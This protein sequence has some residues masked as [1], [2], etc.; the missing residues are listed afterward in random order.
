MSSQVIGIDIGSRSVRAIELRNPDATKPTITRF[1]EVALTADAVRR[2]EVL[3]VSTVAVAIKQ[4]WKT[5]GFT[6]RNVILGMG[7]SRVL[8]RDLVMP[9]APLSQIKES[10]AFHVGDMLPVPVSEALLDFYPISEELGENGPGVKG[11]LIAV[12][13][14]AVSA[15]VAAVSEA[16]LRAVEVDLTP[17]AL[18]RAL[19]PA[20]SS[21][22]LS[23]IIS[24][25][26]NST[27]VVV[28]LDGIPQFVRI[29]ASGGDDVT[30]ALAIRLQITHAQA[31]ALKREVGL[32]FVGATAEQLVAISLAQELTSTLLISLRD[33]LA[34]YIQAH[35]GA[36]FESIILSGGGS[37]LSGLARALGQLVSIP[38]EQTQALSRTQ[39]SLGIKSRSTPEQLESMTTAYGLALGTTL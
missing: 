4:L 37:K 18:A 19:A 28:V 11:L 35:S 10:L 34:F 36:E 17:F 3:E 23:V 31:E 22:G 5:G 30:T 12:I 25:G 24:I 13:K 2:G 6:S 29:I 7:G 38:I 21:R 26:A 20:R 16:G 33:T 27:N 15:N 8:S 9:K 39:L 32:G 14:E 1:H